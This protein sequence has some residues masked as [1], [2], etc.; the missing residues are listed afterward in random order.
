MNKNINALFRK[1]DKNLKGCKSRLHKKLNSI[2]GGNLGDNYEYGGKSAQGT[3]EKESEEDKK[4]KEELENL[5]D[6]AEKKV[7]D[8]VGKDMKRKIEKAQRIE[9]LFMAVDSIIEDPSSAQEQMDILLAASMNIDPQ[10]IKEAAVAVYTV[11]QT[12]DTDAIMAQAK[13]VAET[14]TQAMNALPLDQGEGTGAAAQVMSLGKE[15]ANDPNVQNAV[16]QVKEAAAQT[17]EALGQAADQ[18]K[19]ALGEAKQALGDVKN[20]VGEVKNVVGEVKNVVGDAK[21]IGAELLQS[22]PPEQTAAAVAAASSAASAISSLAEN[23]DS[24][25]NALS[26]VASAL[27]PIMEIGASIP[28]LGVCLLLVNK[29]MKQYRESKELKEILEDMQDS[30]NNSMLLI[31]LI[32][33]TMSIYQMDSASYYSA[34]TQLLAE[35]IGKTKKDKDKKNLEKSLTLLFKEAGYLSKIQLNPS[36]EAKVSSKVQNIM[37]TMKRLLPEAAPTNTDQKRSMIGKVIN[38]TKRQF[39]K[40]SAFYNRFG[41]ASFY[42]AQILK[43]LNI[44][45]N[46][47]IIYN[48]QFEWAQSSF[49]MRIKDKAIKDQKLLD[50]IWTRVEGS[51]E[52]KD[53]L[54]HDDGP[55]VQQGG[56]TRKGG[57]RSNN[58]RKTVRRR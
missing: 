24:V 22:I 54:W 5:E 53:Y 15:V 49:I 31:K 30:I 3:E 18:T 58:R 8:L 46:L 17:K 39:S 10:K 7:E 12:V 44:V 56:R 41:M 9:K 55:A 45:N 32:K 29:L 23:A 25:M 27:E 16:G 13:E 42:K 2:K 28:G 33:T 47:L 37:E 21:A 19:Q 26:T 57:R 4:K 40:V 35:K 14:A 52:F 6:A 36:I 20:V 50:L 1:I 51:Q 38:F 48:S 11:L 34:Q 43:N